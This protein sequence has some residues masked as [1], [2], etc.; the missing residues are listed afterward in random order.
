MERMDIADIRD[1]TV[2][3]F[4]TLRRRLGRGLLSFAVLVS[5]MFV[6]IEGCSN[7]NALGATPYTLSPISSSLRRKPGSNYFTNED[8]E[9]IYL[10]GAHT[11][12]NFQDR[13]RSDQ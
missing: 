6:G 2:T 8:G 13:G 5:T 9:P 10:T 7:N 4:T 11:W 1:N 12:T 3:R